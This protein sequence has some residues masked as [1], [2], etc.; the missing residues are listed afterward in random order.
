MLINLLLKKN[1]D[2]CPL[3]KQV[4]PQKAL[5]SY[6][7]KNNKKHFW[8]TEK[9]YTEWLSSLPVICECHDFDW[10]MNRCVSQA[11]Q[12]TAKK[13][14]ML[15]YREVIKEWLHISAGGYFSPWLQCSI[16]TYI[17]AQH[18]NTDAPEP[19]REGFKVLP[20]DFPKV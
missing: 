17:P 7:R 20:D 14:Y 18:S 13:R 3:P 4:C 10:Q 5:F 1:S 15:I 11:V 12:S 6:L 19:L 16:L 9:N 2:T 8:K